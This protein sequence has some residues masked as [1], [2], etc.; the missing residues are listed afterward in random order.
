VL[1]VDIR[2]SG[3]GWPAEKD[4][5]KKLGHICSVMRMSNKLQ[6]LGSSEVTVIWFSLLAPATMPQP[7]SNLE[8]VSAN[9]RCLDDQSTI[10]LFTSWH[11]Q[12]TKA[13]GAR[14]LYESFS[15]HLHPLHCFSSHKKLSYCTITA[16]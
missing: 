12:L 1:R 6:S 5:R 11:F 14:T 2:Y 7:L 16:G 10:L 15:Y 8:L 4:I 9:L 13:T 3:P